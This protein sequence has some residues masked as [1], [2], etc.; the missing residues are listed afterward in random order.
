[1]KVEHDLEIQW[2]M[3]EEVLFYNKFVP[4]L[5]FAMGKKN[6]TVFAKLYVHKQQ[7]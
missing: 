1:M 5:L 3:Q 2:E 4:Y 7:R 6:A